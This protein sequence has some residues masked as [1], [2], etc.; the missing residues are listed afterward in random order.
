MS[1][2]TDWLIENAEYTITLRYTEFMLLYGA[3]CEALNRLEDGRL[4]PAHDN[5]HIEDLAAL[6]ALCEKL[7]AKTNKPDGGTYW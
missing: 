6:E 7:G 3:V 2:R 5:I 4:N 1:C